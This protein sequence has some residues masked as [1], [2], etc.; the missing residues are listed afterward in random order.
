MALAKT[1]STV[2]GFQAINAYH[3]VEGLSLESKTTMSFHVRSYAEK[4]KPF[5]SETVLSCAYEIDGANPFA[6]AYE[7][8][9][10]L[11]E[12]ADATDC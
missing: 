3:R 12:F 9:K 7:H 6:Q 1:V 2:Y 8:L 10:T 11:T 5:F 4:D